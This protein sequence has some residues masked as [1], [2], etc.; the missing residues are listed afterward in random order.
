MTQVRK[1]GTFETSFAAQTESPFDAELT[2]IFTC[3]DGGSLTVSGFY[4]GDDK[5]VVR[6]MPEAEGIYSFVT[7]SNVKALDGQTGNFLCAGAEGH[8]KVVASG[9]YFEHA[10]G[11]NHNSVGTTCYAWIYQGE[12]I[13]NDTLQ[14]LSCGYFNK[15][16][17]CVFPKWYMLNEQ[18]PDIYPFEGAPGNFDYDKP[19]V[20]L[21]QRLDFYV[22]KLN[23]L[24]IQAD[25][26]LFH[27]YDADNWGFSRMSKEQDLRYIKY[28]T[29][30]L[31][32]FPNVWWSIAN[33]YDIFFR[34]KGNYKSKYNAWKGI[35]KAVSQNDPF[36][37]LVGIHQCVKMFDHGYRYLTHCSLQREGMYLT[38]EST[39]DFQKKYKKPVVW[40]EVAY[41]GNIKPTFGNCMP[42]ELVRRLWEAAIRGGYAGHGE[43]YYAENGVLWWA[44]GGKL[45]GESHC[46]IK[47]LREVLES[48]GNPRFHCCQSAAQ[49]PVGIWEDDV[50]AFYFGDTQ[51]C[52]QDIFLPQK[53]GYRVEVVDT[54]NM[55]RKPLDGIYS[56]ISEIPLPQRPYI[57][58]FTKKVSGEAALPEK[59]DADC[60]L[61]DL[62]HYKGGKLIYRILTKTPI[63]KGNEFALYSSL[64]YLQGMAKDVVT[65][66][67]VAELIGFANDGRLIKHL[68][69]M[70]KSQAG[71]QRG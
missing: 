48:Y 56:G 60:L 34:N 55:E 65:D 40:D 46:R 4:D 15:M 37:H 70:M 50:F 41:E 24:A 67:M 54:W 19:N 18:Q 3:P 2:A 32:A 10:D 9:L 17:M 53:Y 71:G 27:P 33:E 39:G 26:I 8:G 58:V 57:A 66:R 16:R 45:H 44:K 5:F 12:D 22:A 38:T 43:T 20:R 30:R 28:V 42:Q 64:R 29:A 59:F 68:V 69:G 62:R 63:L 7:R 51:S 6:F 13:R 21:F 35:I 31:S 23:E 49:L 61:R 52:R 1:Y 36:R 47:F 25:I 14:E 11:T